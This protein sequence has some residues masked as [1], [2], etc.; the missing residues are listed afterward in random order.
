MIR[1]E[2][3]SK[4]YGRGANI[5]EGVS[6]HL[7]RAEFAF[8]TGPSGAG[9][10]T[11]LK[12]IDR[13]ERATSGRVLVGGRDAAALGRAEVQ[14]HRR[15]L[16]IVFQDF[17]LIPS[18]DVLENVS[19]VLRAIGVPSRE[20]KERALAVLRWVG[21]THRM[22]A[23]PDELSGGEQQRV[24]IA[25]AVAAD[26]DILLAD[27]PTGNLD[28]ALSLEILDVFRRINGRGTTVLIATHDPDLIQAARRRELRL[29]AGRLREIPVPA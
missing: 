12:L 7:D 22:R 21:L 9:K 25:R 27:E 20:Q 1:F 2:N 19:F 29:E 8:L 16:G 24:A 17:R 6:F 28:P 14:A 4:R 10:S 11:L 23:R 5:L 15:R 3:V 18:L 26:P 13:R